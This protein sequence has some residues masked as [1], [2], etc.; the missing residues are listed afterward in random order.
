MLDVRDPDEH[1]V[2]HPHGFT[3]AP[4]GQLVQATDEWV[5]VRCARIVLYDSDGVRAKMTGSWLL[6]MG[7]D[8]YVLDEKAELSDI[9]PETLPPHSLSRPLEHYVINAAELQTNKDITVIDLARSPVYR[10]GHIPGAWFASG[11]E[12]ARDLKA[13]PGT[14]MIVLTSPDGRIAAAN[15]ADA[16]TA[17]S[18]QVRYLSGGT[19]AWTSLGLSLETEARWL[20]DPIDVYKRPYEGTHNAKANMQ[21]YIDWELQLVAQLANDGVAGFHVVRAPG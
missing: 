21:G 11:P 6:Q 19:A 1:A 2:S 7:W 17:V 16:Q 8:V 20:S 12:L 18:R 3:S 10:K 5:G 9:I 13:A 14:G 4:G 15:V